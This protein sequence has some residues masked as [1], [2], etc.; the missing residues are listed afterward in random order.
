MKQSLHKQNLQRRQTESIGCIRQCPWA[1]SSWAPKTVVFYCSKVA[2]CS[3][4]TRTTNFVDLNVNGLDHC[5]P[6]IHSKTSKRTNHRSQTTANIA[7]KQHLLY[8]HHGVRGMHPECQM[9]LQDWTKDSEPR[10]LPL[11]QTKATNYEYHSETLEP[12]SNVCVCSWNFL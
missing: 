11:K 10:F 8:C 6:S 3:T 9:V 2:E 1:G 5:Q 7:D 12:S 4:Q